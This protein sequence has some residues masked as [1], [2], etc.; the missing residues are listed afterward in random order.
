[1]ATQTAECHNPGARASGK[2]AFPLAAKVARRLRLVPTW[3]TLEAI[4]L[5]IESEAKHFRVSFD[6]IAE[7]FVRA[8]NEWSRLPEY[9]FASE[10]QRREIFRLNQLDRFWFDD[11]RW[12]A[13]L[14]YQEFAAEHR[15]QSA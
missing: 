14:A 15:E 8:G 5:A 3:P 11:S 1:M 9:Q 7:M 10:W 12:R 13:K 4:H 6:E 2:R